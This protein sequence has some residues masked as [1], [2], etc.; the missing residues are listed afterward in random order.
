VNL[1]RD[2]A[3]AGFTDVEVRDRP[4]WRQAERAMWEAALA[5]T[6]SDAA[7]RSLRDEG[8]RSLDAFD[9]MRRVFA[10]ATAP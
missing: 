6:E 8:R 4:G 10:T 9:S 2:L 7:M 1:R 3:E 5:A